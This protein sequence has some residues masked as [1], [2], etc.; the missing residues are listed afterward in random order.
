MAVDSDDDVR[1]IVENVAFSDRQVSQGIAV[2]DAII[3]KLAPAGVASDDL[4]VNGLLL[5]AARVKINAGMGIK[6]LKAGTDASAAL[7]LE[8]AKQVMLAT[9]AN[10][11][12]ISDAVIVQRDVSTPESIQVT[13][14]P[15][16]FDAAVSTRT[17]DDFTK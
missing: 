1:S 12:T 5:E 15:D 10:V 3:S 13:F 14:N 8:V 17:Y 2:A 9:A 7:A 11:N 4:K 16:E 6:K